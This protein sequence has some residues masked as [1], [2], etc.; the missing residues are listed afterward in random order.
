[1]A[2]LTASGGA[3]LGDR[4]AAEGGGNAFSASTPAGARVCQ[5]LCPTRWGAHTAAAA[6]AHSFN[7]AYFTMPE[8]SGS[9][10]HCRTSD[11]MR[12]ARD[13]FT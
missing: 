10:P 2:D 1:M 6:A 7:L 5:G 9:F 4:E 11:R 3:S 13:R 8:W 12:A